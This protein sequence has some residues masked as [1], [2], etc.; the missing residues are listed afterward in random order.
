MTTAVPLVILSRQCHVP[1]VN[2]PMPVTTGGSQE[3]DESALS[4]SL[5]LPVKLYLKI[6]SKKLKEIF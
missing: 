1:S 6:K 2:H 4:Q 3:K 5:Q